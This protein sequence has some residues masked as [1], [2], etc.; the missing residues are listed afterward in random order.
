MLHLDGAPVAAEDVDDLQAEGAAGQFVGLGEEPRDL[1][2][3][4][5]VLRS[6]QADEALGVGCTGGRLPGFCGG[7]PGANTP[8]ACPRRLLVVEFLGAPELLVVL[9]LVLL[10][11]G[12]AKLPKMARSVGE[13]VT[14]F[15][16]AM[17]RT[18]DDFPA[19]GEVEV[20]QDVSSTDPDQSPGDSESGGNR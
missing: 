11:F 9:V 2:E 5:D 12:P 15:R 10:L 20:A 16:H 7:R 1:V 18:A 6:D 14:E 19:R 4:D 3:A 13:A 8:D 17:T